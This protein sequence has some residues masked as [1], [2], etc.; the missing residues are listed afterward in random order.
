MPYVDVMPLEPP[1]KGDVEFLQFHDSDKTLAIS[2][3]DSDRLHEMM[4]S[5]HLV[6]RIVTMIGLADGHIRISVTAS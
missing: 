6:G 4:N 2:K 3:D 1:F 5:I